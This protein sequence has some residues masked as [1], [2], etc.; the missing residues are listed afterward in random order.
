[1]KV[2]Q[3]HNRYRVRGGEDVLVDA[4]VRMLRE[5]GVRVCEFVRNSREIR[6][7]LGGR[8]AAFLGGTYSPSAR[9]AMSRLLRRERPDLVHAH[10]LYPL[11]SPSV[12]VACRREGVPVVMSCHNFRLLCPEG[13][14][15]SHG[16]AC[17]QCLGGRE[18]RCVLRNCR[19]NLL[20]SA[21]YALRCYVARRFRLFKN[22]VSLFVAPTHFVR[23]KLAENG[24]GRSEFR[25]VPHMVSAPPSGVDSSH[26]EYAA[27]VGRLS[28]EKGI[29]VLL[30]AAARCPDVPVR[31]AGR[32]SE[33]LEVAAQAAKNVK[34]VGR[35]DRA[36]VDEFYARARFVVVPSVCFESFG[37]AAAE[38]M[39]HGLPVI[40]SRIGGLPEVVEDGTTGLLS[41][42][43]DAA[44]LADG[45]QFLWDRPDV[46]RQ[47]GEAGREKALREYAPEVFFR[48]LTDAYA[49]AIEIGAPRRPAR[50]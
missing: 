36:Q 40:A 10:N 4:I 18:R 12:L 9:A 7:G 1:M 8:A 33:A 45:M 11:L 44:E 19:G 48:R 2:I 41:E 49:R 43:G 32:P 15:F 14:F 34:L 16:A 31:V 25:V 35:L 29:D 22:N 46:G 28:P 27:Y 23:R 6:P 5:R 38:A 20:E 21:G 17:E 39:G 42:P 26:G 3:L 24:F 47:M 50:R 30:A 37:L 13:T